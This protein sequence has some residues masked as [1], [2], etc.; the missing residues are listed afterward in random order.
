MYQARAQA[1]LARTEAKC[2]RS[3]MP[4]G[5]AIHA[6]SHDCTGDIIEAALAETLR[7]P[8]FDK[9]YP[10]QTLQSG[11]DLSRR[12]GT[13]SLH[14]AMIMAAESNG[15][16]GPRV[17]R[18]TSKNVK[19]LMRYAFPQIEASSTMNL[20]GILSNIANKEL[21]AGYQLGE[22]YEVW[23]KVA[24]TKPVSDFK[25][26]TSYRLTGDMEYELVGADGKIKH[27][28]VGEETYT[29][30]AR[31]YAK[32]F[33]LNREQIIN[34][35]LG[36]LD[37]IRT[38]LGAGSARKFNKLFWSL[39]L[40]N[41]THFTALRGNLITGADSE[42]TEDGVGLDIAV[43][44]FNAIVNG[45]GTRSGYT[46]KMLLVPPE[47]QVIAD[48]IYGKINP[49]RVADYNT[50][51]G[52]FEPVTA[53]WLSDSSFANSSQTGWYLLGDPNVLPT[54]VV[55]FL[56]GQESPTIDSADADFDTLGV[57]FRGFHDFGVDWAEWANA[58]KS[59]GQ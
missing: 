5:P 57:D 29:R 16:D 12:N 21:L 58:L 9:M 2:S 33:T 13:M 31:T 54:V 45:D 47:L 18:V 55:S 37:D 28:T 39:W 25:T 48:R 26:V 32:M 6:A 53:T 42:L 46:P 11:R 27:G 19:Q 51:A 35:D 24:R 34:D 20:S 36:A 43:Q 23:R 52:K 56:D 50:F 14:Q 49:T 40:N 10:D 41:S 44:A 7:I 30:R 59:A 17:F 38:Q 1:F 15:W 8:G 4:K 22:Q 3:I